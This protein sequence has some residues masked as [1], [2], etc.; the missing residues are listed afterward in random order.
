MEA[1]QYYNNKN[2]E[3]V[4][5]YVRIILN[6]YAPNDVICIIG[7]FFGKHIG[8]LF[9]IYKDNNNTINIIKRC[10][11]IFINKESL[12]IINKRYSLK[13]YKLNY[14][15][16]LTRY[17]FEYKNPSIISQGLSND[18]VFV[19]TSNGLYVS[20]KEILNLSCILKTQLKQIQCGHK[21][22]LFLTEN[23][24]V[25]G[26]GENIKGQLTKKYI[27]NGD[28]NRI[29]RII[30]TNNIRDIGC[31]AYSSYIIN[32]N[33]KLVSFGNNISGQLGIND[34]SVKHSKSLKL[35]MNGYNID[36]FSCGYAH[37]GCI[38]TN[39]DIYM[40]GYNYYYYSCGLNINQCCHSPNKIELYSNE[41]I[42]SIKCGG[43]HTILK[44]N[45]NNFY[46]F[47]RNN[48]KQLLIDSIDYNISKP[49]LISKDYLNGITQ[50]NGIII[51]ILPTYHNTYIIQKRI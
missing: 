18:D 50:P 48:N 23:G 34:K 22:A 51:D 49:K 5:G 35:A 20:G 3:I 40:C 12:Y 1:P 41:H 10:Q 39:N 44:T 2:K 16:K 29:Q 4:T 13:K 14:Y 19:K 38:T 42:I 47:G 30:K 24:N 25:Y 46:S 7:T 21:H 27:G 32:T 33:D 8:I 31:C 17:N 36:K 26:S 43:Y 15:N 37:I 6:R 45:L 9:D 11:G 28:L